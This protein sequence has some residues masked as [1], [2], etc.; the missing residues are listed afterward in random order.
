MSESYPVLSDQW[1]RERDERTRQRVPERRGLRKDAELGPN[2]KVPIAQPR[3]NFNLTRVSSRLLEYLTGVGK[4]VR[5]A[6]EGDF[7]ILASTTPALSPTV[8][9]LR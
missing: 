9:T 7:S 6:S 8:S 1:M 4:G 3:L 5:V 2:F